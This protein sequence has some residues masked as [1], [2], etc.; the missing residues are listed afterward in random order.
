MTDGDPNG[1]YGPQLN[2]LIWLLI[3]VSGLFLFTRLYLKNCQ[4]RGLWWDD[5]ILLASW[6]ALTAG[7]GVI[8]YVISLGYGKR[9][10]PLSNLPFFGLPVNILSTLMI[11]TNLWGKTSFGVTLLRIPVRWMRIC[12]WCILT[13]LTLTLTASV[14][15][16]MSKKEK[17][18]ATIAMSMGLFAGATAAAKATTIPKVIGPDAKSTTPTASRNSS[19]PPAAPSSPCLPCLERDRRLNPHSEVKTITLIMS[20]Y[21]KILHDLQDDKVLEDGRNGGNRRTEAADGSTTKCIFHLALFDEDIIGDAQRHGINLLG[22]F[23]RFASDKEK[24]KMSGSH[25]TPTMGGDR[26][27]VTT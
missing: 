23:R 27:D 20:L 22:T 9:R 12:V 16:Q 19:A 17:I 15:L 8:A 18:G 11:I 25:Q 24:V 10:I 21:A 26:Y 6:V 13:T 5:W 3:S 14:L 4:N 2:V 7:G 1:D